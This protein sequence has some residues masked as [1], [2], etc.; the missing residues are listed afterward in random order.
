MPGA[1]WLA[2]LWPV[3][4]P[5]AQLS[6]VMVTWI[7]LLVGTLTVTGAKPTPQQLPGKT[8]STSTSP[9]TRSLTWNAGEEP[10]GMKLE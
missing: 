1:H 6:A 2:R 5:K 9:L 4:S 7:S 8:M 3:T 10:R